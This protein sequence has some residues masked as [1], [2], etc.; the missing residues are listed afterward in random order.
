MIVQFAYI[1][2]RKDVK[3]EKQIFVVLG[4]NCPIHTEMQKVSLT[5]GKV[6][7]SST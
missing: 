2:I 6:F 5:I 3:L 1:F 4:K 7:Q